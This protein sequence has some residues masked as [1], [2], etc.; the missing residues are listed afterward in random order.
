MVKNPLSNLFVDGKP[1]RKW[2]FTRLSRVCLPGS[3]PVDRKERAVVLN[4]SEQQRYIVT[5]QVEAFTLDHAF[6]R[7]I[8][9]LYPEISRKDW[10]MIAELDPEHDI[11]MLGARHPL[12]PSH[13][14]A[15]RR[16]Q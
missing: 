6:S 5:V 15:P 4:M 14:N 10:E 9:E 16:I 3:I 13:M 1:V 2:M 11:G 8:N 12:K 7:L